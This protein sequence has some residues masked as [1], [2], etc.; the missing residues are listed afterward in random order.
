[1]LELGPPDRGSREHYLALGPKETLCVFPHQAGLLAR[2]RFLGPGTQPSTSYCL[3]FPV[4]L[5]LESSPTIF[6]P[7]PG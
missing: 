2:Q 7:V 6:K 1:M 5:P 3:V 4:C